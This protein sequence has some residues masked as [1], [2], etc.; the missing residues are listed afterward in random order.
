MRLKPLNRPFVTLPRRS[1]LIRSANSFAAFEA[2]VEVKQPAAIYGINRSTVQD[3]PKRRRVTRR[4]TKLNGDD[5][6][7]VVALYLQGW[8]TETIGPELRVGAGTVRRA[9]V[10]AR[11]EIRHR[12]RTI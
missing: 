12:G 5:I 3:H 8:T 4:R 11:V 6:V 7:K 1:I 9:L 10:Q 2:G